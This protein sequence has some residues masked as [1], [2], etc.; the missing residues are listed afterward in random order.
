MGFYHWR[1]RISLAA[2]QQSLQLVHDQQRPRS[3]ALAI[4][5]R[6]VLRRLIASAAFIAGAQRSRTTSLLG[7]AFGALICGSPAGLGDTLD[8]P[9]HSAPCASDVRAVGQTA[10]PKET[11]RKAMLAWAQGYL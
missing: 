4:R 10:Q 7:L 3:L 11:D 5:L 1:L 6:R 8:V 9:S 2:G